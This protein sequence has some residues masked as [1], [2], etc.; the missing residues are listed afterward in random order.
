MPFNAPKTAQRPVLPAGLHLAR[1]VGLTDL[2]T[3]TVEVKDDKTGQMKAKDLRKVRLAFETPNKRAVFKEDGQEEPFTVGMEATL[4]MH[5]RAS[6][7]KLVENWQGRKFK[8][9]TEADAF[10]L[11]SLLGQPCTITTTVN[12]SAS[13]GKEY[14]KIGSVSPVM[15]GVNVPPQHNP[16]VLYQ[17]QD[18]ANAVFEKLPPFVKET[19]LNSHEAQ[20]W[21]N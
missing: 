12:T 6:L 5:E 8:N 13:S 14:A 3:H 10:D 21:G 7:R 4:S 11:S 17:I 20:G 2:G 19:I 16:S 15:E 1:L 9:Q 18:G